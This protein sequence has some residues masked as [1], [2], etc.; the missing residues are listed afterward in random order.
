MSHV[1]NIDFTSFANSSRLKHEFASFGNKHKVA[2]YI[3]VCDVDRTSIANLFAKNRYDRAVGTENV[4]KTSGNKL[5]IVDITFVVV[6]ALAVYLANAFGTSHHVS[7]ID[8]FVSAY[9]Y[10]G[11]DAI[12]Y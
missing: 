7:G 11:L 9:H 12:F 1:E 8:S 2:F 10:K 5:T 4:A 3:W 6:E